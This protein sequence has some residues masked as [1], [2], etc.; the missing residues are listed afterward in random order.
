MVVLL[1]SAMNFLLFQSYAS[2][3]ITC[4]NIKHSFKVNA[5]SSSCCCFEL[6]YLSNHT[7]RV[8]WAC[9]YFS[10]YYAMKPN[11]IGNAETPRVILRPFIGL[12]A[13]SAAQREG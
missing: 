7:F 3:A 1:A 8:K 9:L 10:K 11:P 2:Q 6:S 4:A 12:S 5:S 13:P